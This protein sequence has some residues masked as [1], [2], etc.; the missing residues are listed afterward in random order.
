MIVNDTLYNYPTEI[1]DQG[2]QTTVILLLLRV[3]AFF[4]KVE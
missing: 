2:F 3:S 4:I 1:K